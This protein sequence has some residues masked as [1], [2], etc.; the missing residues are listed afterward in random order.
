MRGQDLNLQPPG[1]E[2]RFKVGFEH[3]WH[4]LSLST[5][6]PSTFLISLSHCFHCLF[7][8]LGQVMG[9][10]TPSDAEIATEKSRM[11][12]DQT[13]AQLGCFLQ[14]PCSVELN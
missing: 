9:Q 4:F 3:F 2:L 1:Y 5:S 11:I 14:L 8:V 7:P 10:K 13:I 6:E 12:F